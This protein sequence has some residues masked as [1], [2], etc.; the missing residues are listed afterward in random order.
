MFAAPKDW[1]SCVSEAEAIAR[2]AG[3]REL[4]DRI[5]EL[6]EPQAK[7]LVVDLGSGTGL[8]SLA[9]AERSARVW[10][11]DMSPAMGNYLDVKAV[12]ANLENV[13]TVLASVVS[14]SPCR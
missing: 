1:D 13:E 8:L 11:I 7:H 6:A 5:L 12:S 3:F 2:G 4:R 9:F 14:P 10:A